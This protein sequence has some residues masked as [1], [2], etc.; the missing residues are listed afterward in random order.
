MYN[1]VK[2]IG[3]TTSAGFA[4]L[5]RSSHSHPIAT[6]TLS[7]VA[8]FLMVR[9][10]II[11]NYERCCAFGHYFIGGWGT[12]KKFLSNYSGEVKFL[13]SVGLLTLIALALAKR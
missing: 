3:N 1:P 4:A 13:T 7:T 8:V 5:A 2:F 10:L 11:S 9:Q 12:T 6:A